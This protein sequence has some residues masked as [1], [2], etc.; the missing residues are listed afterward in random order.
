VSQ[1]AVERRLTRVRIDASTL[2]YLPEFE[3][4]PAVA[5][6]KMNKCR[7]NARYIRKGLAIYVMGA[8]EV[9]S[10]QRRPESICKWS[11]VSTSDEHIAERLLLLLRE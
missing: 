4:A 5:F 6:T 8:G 1:R 11:Q 9:G 2:R 3:F 7:N 10:A